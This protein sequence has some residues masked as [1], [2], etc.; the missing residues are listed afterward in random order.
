VTGAGDNAGTKHMTILKKKHGTA[1]LAAV[2]ILALGAGMAVAA[3]AA[4]AG[5][6]ASAGEI[7]AFLK[8]K[9]HDSSASAGAGAGSASGASLAAKIDQARADAAKTGGVAAFFAAYEFTSR[10]KFHRGN[11]SGPASGYSV[12]SKDAKIRIEDKGRGNNSVSVDGEE[13]D[14]PAPAGLLLLIDPAKGAGPQDVS[15]LD[16]DQTYEFADAPVYWLGRAANPESSAYL[17]KA[18]EAIKD[19]ARVLDSFIFAIACHDGPQARAFLKKTAVGPRPAKVR[20]KAIFWLGNSG[21]AQALADLKEIYAKERDGAVKKQIVFAM[22]LSKR[23]EATAELIRIAKEDSS[24]DVRKQAVFWLGQKASA[25]SV[26]ALKDIVD[27][28][29]SESG[30]KDQAVF[31]ISQ[32]PKEKSV[33]MLIDLAKAN[34]NPSIRKKAIFWLGQSGDPAALKFFEDILLKK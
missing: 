2:L 6:G 18:F 29:D 33:P 27:A 28:P 4:G 23:P 22:Q 14:T 5:A 24:Q 34:K 25:E 21:D 17:E 31:A 15:L 30:L 7:P 13:K 1:A 12:G 11:Y 16:L 8:G 10:T 32:L 20:E 3:S 19:D 9:V 26:K